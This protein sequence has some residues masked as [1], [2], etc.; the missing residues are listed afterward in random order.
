MR[1][2]IRKSASGPDQRTISHQLREAILADGRSAYSLGQ[3]AEVDPGMIQRF[4]NRERGLTLDSVDRLGLAL[5]LR[6]TVV[7]RSPGRGRPRNPAK[8]ASGVVNH[9]LEHE[10]LASM[11]PDELTSPA[12]ETELID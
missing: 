2:K 12:N 1:T 11:L 8:V 9:H 10:E 6:L 5:G 7:G 3:A 4:L